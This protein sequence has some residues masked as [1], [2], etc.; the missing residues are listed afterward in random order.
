MVLFDFHNKS[1]PEIAL[2]RHPH[3]SAALDL[4]AGVE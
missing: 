4:G 1:I 2:V 3:S